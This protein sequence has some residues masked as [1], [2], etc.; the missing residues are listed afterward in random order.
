MD[1]QKCFWLSFDIILFEGMLGRNIRGHVAFNYQLV[2]S[3]F[4]H[5]GFGS[6]SDPG[7]S[8]SDSTN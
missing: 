5:P 7:W 3:E 1:L 8:N 4:N 6:K 2:E